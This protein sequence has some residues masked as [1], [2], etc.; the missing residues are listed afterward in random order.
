[1]APYGIPRRSFNV[2]AENP[3]PINWRRG[4]FRVWLLF[5]AAWMMGWIIYLVMFGLQEG[6]KTR[7]DFF[8][9]PV[10]LLAPPIALL[11]FGFAAEWAFR[12]FKAENGPSSN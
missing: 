7:G 5:S 1:M 3:S 10:L 12:G 6:F 8:V 9:V 2:A 4:L 11:F